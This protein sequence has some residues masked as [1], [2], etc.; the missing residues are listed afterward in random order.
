M[1]TSMRKKYMDESSVYK[2]NSDGP[3]DRD[4][5]A[6]NSESAASTVEG[7]EEEHTMYEYIVGHLDKFFVEHI[8]VASLKELPPVYMYYGGFVAYL[9][10]FALF[11][12]FVG[13][14]YLAA[15][16]QSY[17]ATD[18]NSGQCESVSIAVTGSYLADKQGNWI[19]SP[20][21]LYSGAKYDLSF[22][23][24]QVTS[25][26]QYVEMME[27]FEAALLSMGAKANV[28]NLPYNLLV[29]ISFIKFYSVEY[30]TATNF[31]SIGTGQLQYIQMTG[32][33]KDTFDLANQIVTIG[34]PRGVCP[35]H[36]ATEFDK[37]NALIK[38]T[39]NFFEYTNDTLCGDALPP[40]QYGYSTAIDDGE[41]ELSLNVET[42]SLA[43]AVNLG[44]LALSD[45]SLASNELIPL[46]FHDTNYLL[47][48]YFDNRN[49]EMIPMS[50][51]YNVSAI[52]PGQPN[53]QYLCFYLYSR[54][55]ALPVFNHVGTSN[56]APAYCACGLNGNS[57]DCND[58][59]LMSGL[60]IFPLTDSSL[61]PLASLS[62]QI[63]QLVATIAKF[64]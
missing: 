62:Y 8:P 34:S 42:L 14:S 20:D 3:I 9:S 7:E 23:N 29:W 25:F 27:T 44:I 41:F 12:Y 39:L 32:N 16:E 28:Q 13:T 24:F 5:G 52:P 57:D 56:F 31:T 6:R 58:F 15:M 10:A 38:T 40:S 59:N 45:L 19:G 2:N 51:I 4:T 35:M 33:A 60:V 37:A 17:I 48:E 64:D 18:K 49:L 22:N 63:N 47:G 11:A 43:M 36:A 50:C 1:S 46:Y 21:F 54:T 61:N 55:V 53:I 30:P 26:S